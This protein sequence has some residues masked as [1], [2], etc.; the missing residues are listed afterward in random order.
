MS[1]N[2]EVRDQIAKDILNCVKKH[3]KD[4]AKVISDKY[5]ISR[6][7]TMNHIKKLIQQGLIEKNGGKS[8]TVYKLTKKVHQFSL[9]LKDLTGEH[10]VWRKNIL[11]ILPQMPQNIFRICE[12]GVQEMINN[13]ID[14]SG[15]HGLVISITYTA[16]DIT[17]SILDDGIG[18]FD[19]I[20]Q[21][22]DLEDSKLAIF[23]LAKGKLTSD[24]ENHSGEGIFFTS[25][26]FDR[27]CI[28]SR[29]LFFYGHKNND[30]LLEN[31]TN[32]LGTNVIMEISFD[33]TTILSEI[34]NEY[35]SG[36]DMSFSKTIIPVDLFQYEGVML[37]SRS[38]A[39]RLISRFDKFK[40]VLLDFNKIEEIGQSFADELFRVFINKHP[41]I[42]LR[43]INTSPGVEKMI[44]HV[45]GGSNER[46][47]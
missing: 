46:S 44:R 45:L 28:L 25:R 2:K 14:H 15:A 12:Y 17:F 19:K 35:T 37:V 34:F 13:V 8:N 16:I 32:Y 21:D 27:F 39:H 33:S 31:N 26:A 40:E 29:N 41:N 22:F 5:S 11:P 43:W 47:S 30:W 18:I 24:P 4:I 10:I 20:Q 9:L 23:E 1:V 3:P 7:S 36:D 6:Q 42:S 38:Q